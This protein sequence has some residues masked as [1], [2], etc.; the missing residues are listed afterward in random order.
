MKEKLK[1]LANE[2]D[3]LRLESVNKVG[4]VRVQ[5]GRFYFD[6]T[7]NPRLNPKR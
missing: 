1:I 6:L 4:I 5:T 3:I 2:I 7:L